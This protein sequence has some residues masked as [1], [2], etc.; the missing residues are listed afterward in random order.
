VFGV[1]FPCE[2][3]VVDL[4]LRFPYK[5]SGIQNR[6]QCLAVFIVGLKNDSAM[7][8]FKIGS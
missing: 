4:F 5:L 3:S 7:F 6:K 1:F 8:L 2:L